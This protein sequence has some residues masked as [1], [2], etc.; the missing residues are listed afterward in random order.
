[1]LPINNKLLFHK[2][3][4]YRFERKSKKNIR[5][6]LLIRNISVSLL[7]NGNAL[8]FRFSVHGFYFRF[9]LNAF[10]NSLLL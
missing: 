8:V 10:V 3:F 1:M 9:Y 2:A 4:I 6:I 5:E 7:R